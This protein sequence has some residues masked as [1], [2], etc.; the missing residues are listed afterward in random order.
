MSASAL[1]RRSCFLAAFSLALMAGLTACSYQSVRHLDRQP[2]VAGTDRKLSMKYLTFEYV[3]ELAP[4]GMRIL[5]TAYP[6]RP[7]IPGWADWAQDIWLATYLC[8]DTGKVLAKQISL[9]PP[10][11]LS[12]DTGFDFDF[13]LEPKDMAGNS[14]VFITFGYR[15]ML[16]ADE[17]V[18]LEALKATSSNDNGL[19]FA[20]E[21][22][23]TRF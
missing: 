17:D 6:K 9:L 4:R 23:L 3:T 15:L 21:S 14:P 22:A 1:S 18:E 5:G 7:D 10:Q 13:H 16:L 20:S 12:P 11:K 2:W 8:N 19:F